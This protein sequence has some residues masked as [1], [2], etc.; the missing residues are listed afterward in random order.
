MQNGKYGKELNNKSTQLELLIIAMVGATLGS[1]QVIHFIFLSIDARMTPSQPVL[2]WLFSM[3]IITFLVHFSFHEIRKVQEDLIEK[4]DQASKAQSRLQHI[5]DNTQDTIFVIDRQG[6]FEFASR[7]I[8]E[9]TG[10]TAAEVVNMR[11]D[12][13]LPY[14]YKALVQ[15]ELS[16]YKEL[17]G[18]H[19]YVD[20]RRKDGGTMRV[21]LCFKKIETEERDRVIQCLARKF[22][23][24]QDIENL[25]M[26]RQLFPLTLAPINQLTKA[27]LPDNYLDLGN[28][29]HRVMLSH[30]PVTALH[31]MR[32]AALVSRV[33]EEL[34][35]EN[36][37]IEWL[38]L[39]AFLHDVGKLAVPYKILNKTGKLSDREFSLVR[40]HAKR[41]I[42]F[43]GSANLPPAV[44]DMILHH[45]ER[46]DGT[47]YPHG[48]TAGSLNMETKILSVC[49]V[50]DSMIS[51]RAYRQALAREEVADALVQGK[52]TKFDTDAVECIL[53]MLNRN[54][55]DPCFSADN[56]ILKVV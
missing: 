16:D 56:D 50:T 7:S 44:Q 28:I 39:G 33:A 25:D 54:A 18:R 22:C 19:I 4:S 15:R 38:K 52:G 21:E 43:L 45:H 3:A 26:R 55:Y 20:F 47:G 40:L 1:L 36:G 49:D 14:E 27:R 24:P 13:I 6:H 11:I 35:I 29:F 37:R 31:Q 34:G 17:G 32:L 9:L 46:L 10:Y 2:D 53:G 5:I 30:D 41:G 23:Q 42:E 51:H 48:L 8:E 12:D